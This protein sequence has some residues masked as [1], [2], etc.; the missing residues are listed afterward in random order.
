MREHNRSTSLFYTLKLIC[1]Y[2]PTYIILSIIK[3]LIGSLISWLM[4]WFPK[5]F[6]ELL[7]TTGTN[8]GAIMF[9]IGIFALI[10]F[11]LWMMEMII[12]ETEAK[13]S[14]RFVHSIRKE[15]GL[16]SMKS[17]FWIIESGEYKEQLNRANHITEILKVIGIVEAIVQGIVTSIGLA[18]L[19][20]G[21]DW[22]VFIVI[23]AALIIKTIFVKITVSYSNKRYMVYG[24]CDRIGNYLTYT[25]YMNAGA[26]KEIRINN[27]RKWFLNKIWKYRNDMLALQYHDYNIYALFDVLSAL[28]MAGQTFIVIISLVNATINESITIPDFTMY[29]NAVTAITLALS[30]VIGDVGEYNRFKVFLGDF[31]E[32]YKP[33]EAENNSKG[34]SILKKGII[35][36]ENVSFKYPGTEKY[37]LKN[38]SFVIQEKEKLAIVGYNGAGKSTLIKL[39]CKFY[40]PSEGNILLDETNIWDIDNKTYYKYISAVFQDYINFAFTVRENIA[41]NG[42][43]S[44]VIEKIK[45]FGFGDIIDDFPNGVETIV[46]RLFDDSGVD[47]SGGEQQKISILRA[48]YKNSLI[49]VLDEPT[50]ALDAKAEA[51]LYENFIKLMKERTAILI[52][53]RLASA[54]IADKILL[55]VDGKIREYG[56]HNELMKQNGVYYDMYTKQS[57]A[58]QGS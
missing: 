30:K 49:S 19:L 10:L 25:G 41:I 54:V 27:A 13:I 37:V 47:F 43:H 33:I 5:Q 16:V 18:V 21:Y 34:E 57:E 15:I 26:A 23:F 42:T 11:V 48:L 8:F 29:F 52:S 22:K 9:R 45:Q 20:L 40:K 28:I 39:L 53:H 50:G 31:S 14:E 58:Y 3:I 51:E 24:K 1:R 17:P 7:L 6:L 12:S 32:L 35:K 36:F 44:D 56:T 46:S 55:L 2:E 4:V 38:V